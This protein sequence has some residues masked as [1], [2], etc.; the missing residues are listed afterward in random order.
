MP[1]DHGRDSR[2]RRGGC[3]KRQDTLPLRPD[4]STNA[5]ADPRALPPGFVLSELQ[6]V[7]ELCRELG[8]KPVTLYCYVG[9]DGALRDHGLRVI[10]GG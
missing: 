8:V 10:A 3:P 4:R 2:R 7:A 9:P 1:C 6:D 5:P